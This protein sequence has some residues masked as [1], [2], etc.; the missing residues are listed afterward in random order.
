MTWRSDPS[1]AT[2]R[3]VATAAG[4]ATA[5]VACCACISLVSRQPDPSTFRP[6]TS[7]LVRSFPVAAVNAPTVSWTAGSPGPR[8]HTI[9]HRGLEATS[10]W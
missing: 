6:T 5:T 2:T 7:R 1:P 9:A 4:T 3:S 8:A 10:R